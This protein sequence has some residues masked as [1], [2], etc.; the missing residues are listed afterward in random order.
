M[1]RRHWHC[2]KSWGGRGTRMR[3]AY[4]CTIAHRTEGAA[5]RHSKNSPRIKKIGGRIKPMPCWGNCPPGEVDLR[6]K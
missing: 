6:G 4:C 2:A 3:H 5:V 1:R